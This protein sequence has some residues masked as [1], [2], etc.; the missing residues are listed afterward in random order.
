MRS[1]SPIVEWCIGGTMSVG[2]D[3]DLYCRLVSAR[4]HRQDVAELLN[5]DNGT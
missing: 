5:G 3:A 1:R 4:V 2:V